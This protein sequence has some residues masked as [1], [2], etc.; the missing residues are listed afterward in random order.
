[1][2]DE[3]KAPSIPITPEGMRVVVQGMID[4]GPNEAMIRAGVEA[5]NAQW[6]PA[7]SWEE[8]VRAVFIAM[9]RQAVSE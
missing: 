9:L 6:R 4:I 5:A 3:S 2:P 8:L 7:G 1:M